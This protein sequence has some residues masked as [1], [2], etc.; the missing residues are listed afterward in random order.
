PWFWLSFGAVAVIAYAMGGRLSRPHWLRI[1]IHTQWAVTLGLLPLLL[2]LFQQVSII[3]PIANAF[4][5]PLISFVVVPFT[6]LGALLPLDWALQLAHS[7]LAACMLLLQWLGD[8]PF[9]TWQQHAPPAWTLLP[10]LFGVLWMLLPRGFPMRWLGVIALFPMFMLQPLHPEFGAMKVAVLDVGQG[11]AVTVRTATH[12]LLY[13]T[14]PRYSSQSDS[15]S[16]IVVPYLRGE[17]I[18]QLD[19][20]IVSHNDTDHSGG[21]ASV[22]AQIPVDWV[23]SSLADNTPVLATHEHML[24]YAGQSWVWDGVRFDMLHPSPSSYEDADIKDNNRSCVLRVTSQFGSLLLTGDI[25]RE[26]EQELLGSF[27]DELASDILIVPHHGSK[28]SSTP[29]F[30]AA[31]QPQVTIFTVGYRNRFGHPKQAVLERYAQTGSK[32]YRSDND[33]AVLLDFSSSKAIAITRW[34]YQAR[35]YWQDATFFKTGTPE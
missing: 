16:R 35:R 17:G 33:G 2:V 15:G 20:L 32:A 14:G 7:I 30:I 6:L 10:A 34:R 24:C 5:I 11:L 27:A 25:E 19:G 21:M 26:A 31:V 29:A 18:R 13:D 12:M 8:L 23:A 9:G 3:S 22:L 1:A 28:T 4:A